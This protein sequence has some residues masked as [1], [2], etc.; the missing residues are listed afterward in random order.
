MKINILPLLAGLM[1]LS[2][3]V[4]SCLDDNKEVEYSDNATITS[5]SI[6][7]IKTTLIDGTDTTVLKVA[8]DKYAFKID[9]IGRRIYN[10]DSLPY[11]TDVR[12][13]VA[14]I[15]TR[16]SGSIT[17]GVKGHDGQDSIC[18]WASGDS[19]D[20]TNP[21][22]FTVHAPD[23]MANR[24]YE[25]R[26]NVHQVDPEVM[27]WN[28]LDDGSFPG[29][30]ITGR[31]KA[32]GF[33]NRMYV[34]SEVGEQVQVASSDN[35][36]AWTS[37]ASLSGVVGKV[38]CSSICVFG[39]Q[40]LLIAD[41]EI[42]VSTD[43]QSWQKASQQADAVVATSS[44]KLLAVN[45]GKFVEG[46]SS[47]DGIRWTQSEVAVPGNFPTGGYTSVS[48]PLRSNSK[49]ETVIMLGQDGAT[50]STT[51]W[52]TYSTD[53]FTWTPY[54]TNM[55]KYNCPKLDNMALIHY[56]DLLYVFG[57]KGVYEGEELTAF[58]RFYTSE[59][60]GLVWKP[61]S[62]KM[63]LP[64][65]LN[66]FEKSFAYWVDEADSLWIMPSDGTAVWRGHLNS[67]SSQRD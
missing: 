27:C 5:F 6:N 24:L 18:T 41:G 55:Y 44:Y 9:Q 20:F 3:V 54:I 47:A 34:F 23:G 21:I 11:R 4:T 61:V 58:Q 66:G 48:I 62:E 56:N 57:G 15:G 45:Q 17:Y 40:L 37:F 64:Q 52:S 32:V 7:D 28:K 31:S 36:L 25:V 29:A 63:G 65:E 67:L 16:V 12:K 1:V 33:L 38:D 46:L 49:I 51:V 35:G 60:Y 50:D 59:N 8:G 13:V 10:N 42:Y 19:L 43:A 14:K 22:V 53:M 39:G 30:N 2:S 26:V